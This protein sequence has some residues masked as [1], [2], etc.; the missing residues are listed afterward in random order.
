MRVA[1]GRFIWALILTLVGAGLAQAQIRVTE[2]QIGCLDLKENRG[3]LTAVVG[4]ACN[5]KPECSYK[6]PTPDQYNRMG[7]K[8]HGRSFCTQGMEIEYQCAGGAA[9][10]TSVPGDAWAH[11]PAELYC[12][13]PPPTKPVIHVT[14]AQIGCLDLKENRDNLTAVVSGACNGKYTCSYKA[15]TPDEY[16]RMKINVHGRTFCTQGMEIEYQCGTGAPR[17]ASVPGDAWTH[18]PAD[19]DCG[20]APP[21]PQTG[22]KLR[23][24]VDLHT[25]PLSNLAFGGKLLYGG[26]DIGSLL[27][28]DPDCNHNIHAASMEQA[29][30]HDNS[31]HGGY[32][33]FH[34]QCGDEIRKQVIHGLQTANHGADPPDDAHGAPDFK[35][36]PAWNDITHQ[37]MWVDWIRRAYGSGLRVMVALAVNNKTLGDATAGPGDYPTDDK[38]SADLQI[39]E[40]KAFISRHND[41]META[42]SSGDLERIVRAN[43]LA[44]VLGVEVDNIGNLHHLSPLTDAEI[45][46]E[47]GRL[48]NEGVRYIFPIHV[49]DNPFGGTAAYLGTF[50]L[51][52]YRE[53]GHFWDLECSASGDQIT[54]KYQPDGFD[55]A[56]ALVKA[57]KLHIDILRNPG[58]PPNCS[59]GTGHV[60]SR[61]LTPQGEFAI[62]EMMR[63]GMLIDVDHMSEK[64]TLRALQIAEAVP[65]KYPLNSGHSGVRGILNANSERS[66]TAA[67][68]RRIG[69]AHGMAGVGSADSDAYTWIQEYN[70]VVQAMGSGAVAG[71]GTDTDGLAMGMP[72]RLKLGVVPKTLLNPLG[73]APASSVKYDASFPKSRLGNR[74]WDYNSQGVV[75]Y[76]MLADFL[77]DARTAPNGANLIDNN[78]MNGAQYFLDTWKK[79]EAL[80][81][82]VK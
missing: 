48:Y 10:T 77:K 56:I 22:A 66:L 20:A 49:I 28:A 82:G 19:L 46:S 72:P 23:G 2:A 16:N 11:P 79:C 40:T 53:A 58:T 44:I 80:K 41:F 54:Y 21:P 62:K 52:N 24:Y 59:P 9:K 39:T 63:H 57:T 50:N 32:D 76:G 27:P 43:K 33:L 30:G 51:S 34:N 26:V 42:Y 36:W 6:A 68:Y 18:P 35:D 14:E 67:Q 74:E 47:I 69:D 71:F 17:S 7:V 60:N 55:V 13:A 5:G 75:H 4:N 31:T 81:G 73:A 15:P 37:K 38:A 61:G 8:V 65:G 29:L 64:S 45:S 25:H 78:L 1:T 3:N 70:A 12:G